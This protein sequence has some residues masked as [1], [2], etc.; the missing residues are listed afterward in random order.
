MSEHACGGSLLRRAWQGAHMESVTVVIDMS[1][2]IKAS[3]NLE[4][5][6]NSNGE[7]I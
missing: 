2:E 6:N 4:E 1:E 7:E 5:A 3:K